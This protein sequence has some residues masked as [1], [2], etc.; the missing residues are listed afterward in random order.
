MFF[1]TT[2]LFLSTI[3]YTHLLYPHTNTMFNQRLVS[4]IAL[5]SSHCAC[6]CFLSAL[7]DWCWQMTDCQGPLIT[8]TAPAAHFHSLSLWLTLCI[9]SLTDSPAERMKKMKI[10]LKCM[11]RKGWIF[12]VEHVFL[13]RDLMRMHINRTHLL[14]TFHVS[15]R[16]ILS[17]FNQY[18][19]SCFH[20]Q[21]LKLCCN[22]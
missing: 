5:P 3:L 16:R 8:Q 6:G 11:K 17:F 13:W 2:L 15:C 20:S 12:R 9:H 10:I 18:L 19:K 14:R 1:S 4:G 22:S 7:D 21:L